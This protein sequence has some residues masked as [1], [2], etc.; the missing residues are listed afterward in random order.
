MNGCLFAASWFV[1]GGMPM[2]PDSDRCQVQSM[3]DARDNALANAISLARTIVRESSPASLAM[4]HERH[5]NRITSSSLRSTVFARQLIFV[6]IESAA[7]ESSSA[8]CGLG[9]ASELGI[10]T[11]LLSN[12]LNNEWHEMIQQLLSHQRAGGHHQGADQFISV[13]GANN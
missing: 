10:V 8:G 11:S 1:S 9:A 5:L 6:D 7:T 4:V 13:L 12:W 3:G 2:R